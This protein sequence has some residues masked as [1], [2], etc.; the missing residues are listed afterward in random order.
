MKLHLLLFAFLWHR[1]QPITSEK[2]VVKPLPQEQYKYYDLSVVPPDAI[3]HRKTKGYDFPNNKQ[4]DSEEDGISINVV[5]DGPVVGSS[6]GDSGETIAMIEDSSSTR[7]MTSRNLIDVNITTLKDRNIEPVLFF[8]NRNSGGQA[9]AALIKTLRQLDL[10]PVQI[11]DLRKDRP[12]TRL[13]LFAALSDKVHVLV[14]GGDGTLNW[15]MDEL[16]ALNMTVKSFGII[17][18]GTGNDL[19]LHTMTEILQRDEKQGIPQMMQRT[20]VSLRQLQSNPKEV[21]ASH[22]FQMSGAESASMDTQPN[23]N[24]PPNL[25]KNTVKD[26][27]NE[28]DIM[29]GMSVPQMG[30]EAQGKEETKV[31]SNVNSN[32]LPGT[33][34]APVVSLDRWNVEIRNIKKNR[35][36]KKKQVIG[37]NTMMESID[38]DDKHDKEPSQDDVDVMTSVQQPVESIVTGALVKGVYRRKTLGVFMRSMF[39]KLNDK[40]NPFRFLHKHK[41]RNMVMS[42]YIGFGVDGAVSLSM[43]I[44]RTYAPYLFFHSMVNKFWYGVSTTIIASLFACISS[45]YIFS[46]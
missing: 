3:I 6:D 29:S 37:D 36:K 41:H 42:N 9:G 32:H 33:I 23:V 15:L 1:D 13:K 28:K 7:R 27:L 43:D 8:I 30:A 18:L 31:Y 35:K 22:I 16:F 40:L 26:V 24:L 38:N 25:L 34:E 46:H 45:L 4:S 12:S 19:Y 17:P 14:A 5:E 44:M 39:Q 10:H 2:I 21:I 11:C 20:G